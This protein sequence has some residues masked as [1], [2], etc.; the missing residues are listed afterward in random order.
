VFFR[1]LPSRSE[2]DFS[3]TV[4][5]KERE[6]VT[7]EEDRPFKDEATAKSQKAEQWS[8]R[9]VDLKKAKPPDERLTPW[10][11]G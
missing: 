1:V 7:A 10:F 8:Q 4:D 11:R 5:L 6:R 3:W 9:I 2:S